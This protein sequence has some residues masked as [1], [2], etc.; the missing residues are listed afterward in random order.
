MKKL[1]FVGN[2]F[3]YYHD[4]P[5]MLEK[6][7]C[8]AGY[9]IQ[10]AAVTK[11]GWYLERYADPDNEMYPLLHETHEQRAWD[12]IV[13]QDQSFSPAGHPERYLAAVRTLCSQLPCRERFVIYQ[14][15]AY[16][17][18][19]EK[20]QGTGMTY[21][22]MH[23]ALRDACRQAAKQQ[24]ALLVPVGDAFR[25]CHDTRPE[26]GLYMPDHYHPSPDGT[27]LAACVFFAALSGRDP[28]TLDGIPDIAPDTAATL[29]SI[30]RDTLQ[31]STKEDF[32]CAT[33]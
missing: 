29:R 19:T 27:S 15:W 17:D 25:L 14:T 8:A 11:G 22:Q 16:E 23:E 26:I 30:A 4:L 12:M 20:L 31:G 3:T 9:S 21:Q 6:L 13:L 10:T 24:N 7:S 28:R 1:L 2:S 18:G 33:Y 5:A 32:A